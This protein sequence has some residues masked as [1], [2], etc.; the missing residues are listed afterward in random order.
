MFITLC[1]Y[2]YVNIC[3]HMRLYI[4]IYCSL[5]ICK[6]HNINKRTNYQILLT[7]HK[8]L[9][10]IFFSFLFRHPTVTSAIHY[11]HLKNKLPQP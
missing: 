11:Y 1:K 10:Y 9:E 3:I 4:Y 2:L 7:H 6:V 5:L 8:Y